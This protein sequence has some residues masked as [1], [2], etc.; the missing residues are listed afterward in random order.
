MEE[1]PSLESQKENVSAT[2]TFLQVMRTVYVEPVM[3]IYMICLYYLIPVADTLYLYKVC[4]T[5]YHYDVDL[6]E[7]LVRGN[8]TQ[9]TTEEESAVSTE[10]GAWMFYQTI[11]FTIPSMIVTMLMGLYGDKYGRRL[12]LISP[13]IGQGIGC[14][15]YLIMSAYPD[16]HVKYML[17]GA[18]ITGLSGGYACVIMAS[19]SH[20][21]VMI[22]SKNRTVRLVV[23]QSVMGLGTVVGCFTVGAINGPEMGIQTGWITTFLVI[24][25]LSI[26]GG[27]YIVIRFRNLQY[28]SS[29]SISYST[30]ENRL[31]SAYNSLN[32]GKV[33]TTVCCPF[34]S[35]IQVVMIAIW[36]AWVEGLGEF[37]VLYSYAQRMGQNVSIYVYYTGYSAA[38]Q[39]ISAAVA[40]LILKR[41]FNMKDSIIALMGLASAALELL[42]LGISGFVGANTVAFTVL[43]W[44]SPTVG[45]FKNNGP[46][47]LSSIAAGLIPASDHSKLFAFISASDAL[48]QLATSGF[49]SFLL[50]HYTEE[51]L[52][53][54][55]FLVSLGLVVCSSALTC[56]IHQ[57]LK[58]RSINEDEQ[59]LSV[60]CDE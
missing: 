6:C 34:P 43:W 13:F 8:I 28:P 47:S 3:F 25:F 56:I 54:F 11:V 33:L 60:E 21:S 48:L 53:S 26:F 39:A 30:S 52:P 37:D 32:I 27:L 55:S 12:P 19:F 50:W 29:S 59:P 10:T 31:T 51:N 41:I 46:S 45:M 17:V 22:P 9:N 18:F 40:V 42:L 15:Y 38:L 5:I 23:L 16:V 58:T 36:L 44:A 24:I 7:N 2:K 49:Y 20:I 4:R 1:P 14:C 35:L 57:R